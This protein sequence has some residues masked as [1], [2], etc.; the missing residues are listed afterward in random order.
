VKIQPNYSSIQN[1]FI[2][3]NVYTKQFLEQILGREINSSDFITIAYNPTLESSKLGS[4]DRDSQCFANKLNNKEFSYYNNLFPKPDNT[5]YYLLETNEPRSDIPYPS[6]HPVSSIIDLHWG[7]NA[8][9][10]T[11]YSLEIKYQL[12]IFKSF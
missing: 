7:K 9:S 4:P 8:S 11:G 3:F 6:P 1:G 5:H 2:V 10:S 12:P